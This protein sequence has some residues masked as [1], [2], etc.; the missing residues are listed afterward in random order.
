MLRV[1]HTIMLR[2]GVMECLFLFFSVLVAILPTFYAVNQW[3]IR[4]FCTEASGPMRE[5][6][7][8]RMRVTRLSPLY[9]NILSLESII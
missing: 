3:Y 1:G 7:N 6:T 9:S 5:K 4:I 2:L 8:S